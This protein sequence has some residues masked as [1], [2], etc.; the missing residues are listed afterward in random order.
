MRE[1]RNGRHPRYR[2]YRHTRQ[3]CRQVPRSIKSS[4]LF[5]ENH[6]RSSPSPSLGP[7]CASTLP[8]TRAGSTSTTVPKPTSYPQFMNPKTNLNES[9]QVH[10]VPPLHR[11]SLSPTTT[12]AF[13]SGARTTTSAT[14]TH[15]SSR[16]PVKHFPSFFARRG[17][18]LF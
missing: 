13:P 5:W 14:C 7:E 11:S 17:P 15:L 4:T 9:L 8:L 18:T 16:P 1:G 6:S 2:P 12:C 10:S 3:Q